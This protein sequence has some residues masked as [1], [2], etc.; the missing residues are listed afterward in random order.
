[1]LIDVGQDGT[2]A[3]ICKMLMVIP[4][5]PFFAKPNPMFTIE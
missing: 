2:N 4:S 1:M 5:S 3:G